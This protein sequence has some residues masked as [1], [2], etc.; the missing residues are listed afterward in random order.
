MSNI[1][2]QVRSALDIPIFHKIYNLYK[3]LHG[4]QS[5]IPKFQ[6]YT[7]WQKCENTTLALLEAIIETNYQQEKERLHSLHTISNK[8]DL[9]KC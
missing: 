4:Y 7:L 9:L 5:R 1:M 6:R 2:T 3:I 8:L